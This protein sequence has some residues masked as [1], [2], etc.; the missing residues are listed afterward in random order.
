MSIE[1]I[2]KATHGTYYIGSRDERDTVVIRRAADQFRELDLRLD[3]A[4]HSPS[5]FNWGYGGSG[6]A[7]LA[8]AL[9][10]DFFGNPRSPVA[11]QL[12]LSLYQDFKFRVIANLDANNWKLTRSQIAKTIR[13]LMLEQPEHYAACIEFRLSALAWDEIWA[14]ERE[15]CSSHT[16]YERVEAAATARLMEATRE[17]LIAR[18]KMTRAQADQLLIGNPLGPPQMIGDNTPPISIEALGK[19]AARNPNEHRINRKRL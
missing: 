19:A 4:K 17:I 7:Q 16:D 2:E 8:L 1:N 18:L 10:A 12:A 11:D 14:L 9:L 15:Q 5:G 3:L 6:P 13:Q